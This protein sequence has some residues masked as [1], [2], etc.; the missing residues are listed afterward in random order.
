[1]SDEYDHSIHKPSVPSQKISDLKSQTIPDKM[2]SNQVNK[3]FNNQNTFTYPTDAE[4]NKAEV[5][6]KLD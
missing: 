4:D 3:G 2:T 5:E 6:K 1:M